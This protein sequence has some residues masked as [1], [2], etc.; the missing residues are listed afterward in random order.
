MS[1]ATTTASI[2]NT[3]KKAFS[4]WSKIILLGSIAIFSAKSF[5]FDQHLTVSK[6]EQLE[7]TASDLSNDVSYECGC[8]NTARILSDI[9]SLTVDIEM[10]ARFGTAKS[11]TPYLKKV[12]YK[13]KD[14]KQYVAHIDDRQLRLRIKRELGLAVNE[15]GRAIMGR[16][17]V[18]V[19]APACD[20]SSGSCQDNS[21][22]ADFDAII[23]NINSEPEE[24]N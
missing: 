21:T 4:R 24:L 2:N 5:A 9:A 6:A 20:G 22:D 16:G 17:W 3:T 18:T 12:L 11:T 7:S 13:V 10:E 8:T 14:L 19:H 23:E 1:I 15:L